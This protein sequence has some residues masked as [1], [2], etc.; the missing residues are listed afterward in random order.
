M[1]KYKPYK[2][3]ELSAKYAETIIEG[4]KSTGSGNDEIMGDLKNRFSLQL[5]IKF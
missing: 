5:D 4:A 3:L 2:F 1:L